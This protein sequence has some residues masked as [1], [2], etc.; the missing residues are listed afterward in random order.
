[1]TQSLQ[2]KGHPVMQHGLE[3]EMLI[4]TNNSYYIM[5]KFNLSR[6]VTNAESQTSA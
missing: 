4:T 6:K 5:A 1:M 3:N 2:F